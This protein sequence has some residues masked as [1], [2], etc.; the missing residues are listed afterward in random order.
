MNLADESLKAPG[1]IR[2]PQLGKKVRAYL[3]KWG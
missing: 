3:A 1:G 2:D